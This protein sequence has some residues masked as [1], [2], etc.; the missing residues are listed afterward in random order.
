M[1]KLERP[2][3]N[4]W[5]HIEQPKNPSEKLW[6][7]SKGKCLGITPECRESCLKFW[8]WIEEQGCHHFDKGICRLYYSTNNG[9]SFGR[10][11]V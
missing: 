6:L 4:E 1:T 11:N 5:S 10:S 8:C 9:N 7:Q 3:P 2:D